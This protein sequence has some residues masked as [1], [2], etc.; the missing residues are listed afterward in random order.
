MERRGKSGARRADSVAARFRVSRLGGGCACAL[1]LALFLFSPYAKRSAEVVGAACIRATAGAGFTLRGVVVFGRYRTTQNAILKALGVAVGDPLFSFDLAAMR[2]RVMALEWVKEATV[3]RA[4]T[5]GLNVY[6]VEREPI[7]VYHDKITKTFSLVD[8]EGKL[9]HA[10]ILPCFRGLPVLSGAGAPE[11]A[12][13]M[14]K[15]LEAFPEIRKRVTAMAFV[16]GRRWNLRLNTVEVKLPEKGKKKALE[17]LR[18]LLR[19]K[20]IATGD[21]TVVDLRLPEKAVFKLS[22][23]G[24]AFFKSYRSNRAV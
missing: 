9:I 19:H 5:G 18:I 4:L 17:V 12:Q 15:R 6:L 7:A 24:Q 11:H 21:I 20:K 10:P 3:R 2:Q 16:D 23:A 22:P 1:A 8:T 14:L 13:K